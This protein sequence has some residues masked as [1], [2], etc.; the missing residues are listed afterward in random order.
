MILNNLINLIK[1]NK[2][3]PLDL[4]KA[5]IDLNQ[6]QRKNFDP[7][8]QKQLD[9]LK[10]H[11]ITHF[12]SFYQNELSVL[13]DKQRWKFAFLLLSKANEFLPFEILDETIPQIPLIF[14]GE[15]ESD[16]IELLIE[17]F[18]IAKYEY[19]FTINEMGEFAELLALHNQLSL[20]HSLEVIRFVV[21]IGLYNYAESLDDFLDWE[22][23]IRLTFNEVEKF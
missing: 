3:K 20:A 23:Y 11:I 13:T 12:Q 14:T 22:K 17:E 19:G 2:N 7:E 15:L 21:N 16:Y 4:L 1:G 18:Q 10:A 9:G 5:Y 8:K 6:E